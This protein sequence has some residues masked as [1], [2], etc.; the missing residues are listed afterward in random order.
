MHNF[1]HSGQ[2]LRSTLEAS[3]TMPLGL[4]L[5]LASTQ[6]LNGSGWYPCGYGLCRPI[7]LFRQPSQS[8]SSCVS[9]I[10]MQRRTKVSHLVFKNMDLYNS[11]Y[12]E[13]TPYLFTPNLVPHLFHGTF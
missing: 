4:V 11:D 5:S 7:V 9:T 6:A 12:C 3:S 10:T 13:T 8:G 1:K 2:P